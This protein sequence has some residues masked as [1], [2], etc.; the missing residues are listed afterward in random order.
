ME[1]LLVPDLKAMSNA[2]E[3]HVLEHSKKEKDPAKAERESERLWNL[4]IAEVFQKASA[5]AKVVH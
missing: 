2:L 5:L 4:L 1:I 3:A